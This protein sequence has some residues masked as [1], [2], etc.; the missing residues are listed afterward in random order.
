MKVYARPQTSPEEYV[1]AHAHHPKVVKARCQIS[2]TLVSTPET[3]DNSFR[4]GTDGEF[5]LV[6]YRATS[7]PLLFE[8]T[9]QEK[10]EEPTS[11]D[12]I[13]K[14]YKIYVIVSF[15]DLWENKTV[16][17]AILSAMS[18]QRKRLRQPMIILMMI[19]SG[20]G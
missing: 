3:S 19:R 20:S 1:P 17:K 6:G 10:E 14:M 16:V 12:M 4:R 5:S 11:V 2:G 13:Y 8:I 18:S 9:Y 15:L 7:A